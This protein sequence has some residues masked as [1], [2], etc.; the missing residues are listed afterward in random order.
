M[1][2]AEFIRALRLG[3]GMIVDDVPVAVAEGVD[4]LE[5]RSPC[6]G[7]EACKGLED[8]VR[9]DFDLCRCR[10]SDVECMGNMPMSPDASMVSLAACFSTA[11]VE[12][13]PRV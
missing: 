6:G 4:I 3:L 9:F 13:I 5:E 2:G 10:L 12:E 8:L 1:L 11:F 7:S